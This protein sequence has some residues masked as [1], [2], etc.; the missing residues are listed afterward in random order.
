MELS[1]EIKKVSKEE[2]LLLSG[3]LDEDSEVILPNLLSKL[4]KKVCVIN[5]RNIQTVNSCGVRAWIN[6][7]RELELK[8]SVYFEECPPEVVSQINMIPSSL[9]SRSL[10]YLCFIMFLLTNYW[11]KTN[12]HR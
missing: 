9:E 12:R 6:F 5:F 11:S 4:S 10:I 2:T 8:A 3:S 7:L 1:Y